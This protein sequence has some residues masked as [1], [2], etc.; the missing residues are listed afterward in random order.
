MA[1]YREWKG[2]DGECGWCGGAYICVR[3]SLRPHFR[4]RAGVPNLLGPQDAFI[5]SSF[6]PLIHPLYKAV[7]N[8]PYFKGHVHGLLKAIEIGVS[9][10]KGPPTWP[11]RT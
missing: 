8:L 2:K 10:E 11:G 1:G 6:L 4:K 3:Q 5:S 9:D 7:S